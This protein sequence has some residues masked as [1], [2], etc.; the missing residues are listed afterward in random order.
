MEFVL[1]RWLAGVPDLERAPRNLTEF[2]RSCLWLSPRLKDWLE[3][4][5]DWFDPTKS[6]AYTNQVSRLSSEFRDRHIVKLLTEAVKN[7][8]RVFAVVGF[9]HVV[10]QERA[11]KAALSGAQ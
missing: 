4:P 7:G 5:A 8:A 11:L 1:H 10:M 2:E 6:E 3:T 9:S